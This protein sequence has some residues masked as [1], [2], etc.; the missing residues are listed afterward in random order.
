MTRGDLCISLDTVIVTSLP[1]SREQHSTISHSIKKCHRNSIHQVQCSN[2]HHQPETALLSRPESPPA[3]AITERP[4]GPIS[5]SS[6]RLQ[7]KVDRPKP[8]TNDRPLPPDRQ[9]T[10][11]DRTKEKSFIKSS[12]LGNSE[13]WPPSPTRPLTQHRRRSV[14]SVRTHSQLFLQR[15]GCDDGTET[16]FSRTPQPR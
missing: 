4:P 13:P 11:L 16:Y 8:C 6:H 15:Q 2:Q 5:S 7:R 12:W 3:S 14:A 1:S 10:E 9:Q